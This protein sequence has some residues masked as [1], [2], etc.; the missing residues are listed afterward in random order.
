MWCAGSLPH[1]S[2]CSR[3]EGVRPGAVA[4][5]AWHSSCSTPSSSTA[6]EPTIIPCRAVSTAALSPS[7]LAACRRRENDAAAGV[8][9]PPP[10]GVPS[11]TPSP[12]LPLPPPPTSTA[13]RPLAAWSGRAASPS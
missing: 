7:S 6:V 5:L 4:V 2:W 8:A 1:A 12:G 3:P 13:W 10:S 11:P 9:K